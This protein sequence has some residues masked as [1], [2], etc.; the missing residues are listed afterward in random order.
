MAKGG[1][2]NTVRHHFADHRSHLL[3]CGVAVVLVVMAA[4]VGLPVLAVLGGLLCAT[5]MIGM[6]W[7][8]VAMG[9][10]HRR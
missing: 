2:M 7:M 6:A 9:A 3:G 1:L 10:K 4:V 8:M 5:M